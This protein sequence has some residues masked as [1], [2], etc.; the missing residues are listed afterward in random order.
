[1]S[2]LKVLLLGAP[3]VLLDEQPVQIQRR[4][5]RTLLYYLA[6][7]TSMTSRDELLLLFWP[8]EPED[9]A[10]KNL[11]ENLS[12]LKSQLLN[13]GLLLTDRE[14][15]GLD[16]SQLYSDVLDFQTLDRQSRPVVQRADRS[17]PL[18]E[19][20]YQQI[21]QAVELWRS[22]HFLSGA[23]LAEGGEIE[24][25]VRDFGHTLE[26]TRLSML[27]RIADHHIAQ[28][29]LEMAVRRLRMALAIDEM[30][31][32]L[33]YRFLSC[34]QDLG[35]RSEAI[36][37]ASYLQRLFQEEGEEIPL[38]LLELC[39][40]IRNQVA[41][42]PAT[43]SISWPV[44][45]SLRA[46]FIGRDYFMKELTRLYET[47]GA[48]AILG[49]GGAGKTRLVFEFFQSL[50]PSPRLLVAPSRPI[51]TSLPFQPVLDLLRQP[52][53]Q[54]E[55]QQLDP[56]WANLIQWIIPELDLPKSS[57]ETGLLESAE[58]INSPQ[59]I[60]RN[61]PNRGHGINEGRALIFE[62]LHQFLLITAQSQRI[63]F[64]LDDAQWC[65]EATLSCLV[66]LI[67]KN[68]FNQHGL[69]VIAARPE[70]TNPYLKDL[71]DPVKSSI[72]INQLELSQFNLA[73]VTELTNHV[74]GQAPSENVAL[75]MVR[76][77]NGNPLLLLETLRTI[78]E[79]YSGS[80]LPNQLE[81]FPI[82]GNIQALLHERLRQLHPQARKILVT[83]AVIGNE[84]SPQ[85]IEAAT[86]LD[87]EQVVE[88]LEEMEGAYLVLPAPNLT[89][90]S[91]YAFAHD[92]I[93]E[94]L[95]SEAGAARKR[96]T[97]LRVAGAIESVQINYSDHRSAVLASHYEQGGELQKAFS[98]WV[99]AGQYAR[100]LFSRA[101]AY[102]AFHRAERILPKLVNPAEKDIYQ[103]YSSWGE[104]AE[105]LI[106]HRT[107][108]D[109]YPRLLQIGERKHSSLLA[110]TALSG[111][112]Y[113]LT[114]SGQ[115]E[116]AMGCFRRAFGYL[117]HSENNFEYMACYSRYAL[118]LAMQNR[119]PEADKA[120]QSA[121]EMIQDPPDR[122]MLEAL[123]NIEAGLAMINNLAGWPTKAIQ[124][125]EHG[126]QTS[127]KQFISSGVT[128][129]NSMLAVSL[130]FHGHYEQALSQC[131][132][133]MPV[134]EAIQN[135]R[136][137]G[138]F[139]LVA[140]RSELA[141][142]HIDQSWE[143]TQ[144]ASGIA[145]KYGFRET[146]CESQCLKGDIYSALQDY[147]KAAEAYQ[148]GVL[149]DQP[150]YESINNLYRLGYVFVESGQ[151]AT[152]ED[153]LVKA[154]DLG[155]QSN[156][157]MIFI[158]A[159]ICLA[160]SH[161]RYLPVGTIQK[162]IARLDGYRQIDELSLQKGYLNV[163]KT[164]LALREE[165]PDEAFIYAQAVIDIGRSSGHIWLE[166]NGQRL[167]LQC[168]GLE[169]SLYQSA[170]QRLI[171]I[172]DTIGQHT[173]NSEL[174]P[175]FER[176]AQ[177]IQ[178]NER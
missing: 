144:A 109:I 169:P 67:K 80:G 115:L 92:R 173:Q 94:V 125:A 100:S 6:S 42:S 174:H 16:Q 36:N 136:L 70:E 72:G 46:P 32:S 50:K 101:E 73:E 23:A 58:E 25:W 105:I 89:Q 43:S 82:S 27:D 137:A 154:I 85:L 171:E 45:M 77:T 74:L 5:Q 97:H 126:L 54:E 142:G 33:H 103:L 76:E 93:R 127:Q 161:V 162:E 120:L 35:R 62:A 3:Q 26:W 113:G 133:N 147:A 29:D 176:C 90:V 15:I 121:V 123:V 91:G 135:W 140:A 24:K 107:M 163:L 81:S 39:Q 178:Q 175:I 153:L 117:E 119:F 21:S 9:I 13:N 104:M 79:V 86:S 8:D 159:E 28:G 98:Y 130:F 63:L 78:I 118:L 146:I 139:Y 141:V 65:D 41:V 20:I 152:G 166:L 48:V 149:I 1:M 150:S 53:F 61:L 19:E 60:T 47:G 18:P 31:A 96:L 7:R 111:L 55:L 30:N 128:Q 177:T 165:R 148:K 11:R 10:R 132:F 143:Y 116:Q 12:R 124:L 68:F 66:Y 49:E 95:L 114:L 51:E 84:F 40:V 164:E 22:P 122:R 75:R 108:L 156:L 37:H 88:A 167:V 160:L 56:F 38:A 106:D 155:H 4:T 158:P 57:L 172:M 138:L 99:Q 69:L 2:A 129:L 145:D 64:F 151:R 134:A 83:A 34:L 170:R 112:G 157:G 168:T 131:Q 87:A 17:K 102:A 52:V 14:Y 44:S 110:G 71:L 59:R